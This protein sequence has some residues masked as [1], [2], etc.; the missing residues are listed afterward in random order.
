VNPDFADLLDALTGTGARFL[1]VGAHA[2]AVHGVPRATG[3]LDIWIETSAD[4]AE[5]VW[6]ALT[7]FG[8]PVESLKMTAEDF[9]RPDMIV[10]VGLPPRRIDLL[11][12]VSGLTFAD[13]WEDRVIQKVGSVAVP[14]LGRSSLV[15]NK[16]ATGRLKDLADLEAL[17][18]K[19]A[20]AD[21]EV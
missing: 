8:A 14:F 21:P 10:Q 5:R 12:G 17:G 16:R 19:P 13:A 15:R 9:S 6:R 3:D 1:V 2:L 20:P 4:N 7:I 11:T 18:E